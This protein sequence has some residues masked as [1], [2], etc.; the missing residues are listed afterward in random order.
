MN[1]TNM[2][3]YQQQWAKDYEALKQI[4]QANM[5]EIAKWED[6]ELKGSASL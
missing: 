1:L 3:S 4:R 5:N 2:T 6:Y